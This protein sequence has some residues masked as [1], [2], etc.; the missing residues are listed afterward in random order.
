[1]NPGPDCERA[2]HQLM[3]ALDGETVAAEAEPPAEARHHLGYCASCGQWWQDLEALNR[4]FHGVLY[5]G[6]DVDLWAVVRRKLDDSDAGQPLTYWLGLIG[7][8][9]VGWRA[10]QLFVDL[11]FPV[12]HPVVPL[13]GAIVGLWLIARDPLAIETFAPELEKRGV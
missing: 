9:V 12:L 8:L 11:P 4:R 1:M 6:E 2:R 10:L 7:A 13:A 5:R 3:A